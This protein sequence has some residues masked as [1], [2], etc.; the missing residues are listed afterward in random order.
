MARA[1]VAPIGC[2]QDLILR[3]VGEHSRGLAVAE[4]PPVSFVLIGIDKPYIRA[5]PTVGRHNLADGM[6]I[7]LDQVG[8]GRGKFAVVKP[9]QDR[10]TYFSSSPATMLNE[11]SAATASERYPPFT[12]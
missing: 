12:R 4:K 8:G 6:G 7:E 5:A 11:P 10:H 2:V 3:G 1:R 9:I